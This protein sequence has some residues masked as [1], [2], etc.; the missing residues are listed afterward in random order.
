MAASTV[1]LASSADLAVADVDAGGPFDVRSTTA[2]SRSTE[3]ERNDDIS[4]EP[5]E[6]FPTCHRKGGKARIVS[7][8][9]G[10][11][12]A[13]A[14]T[15]AVLPQEVERSEWNLAVFRKERLFKI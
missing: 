7:G 10:T 11:S 3:K 12:E 5:Y 1:F 13:R 14:G 15:N 9:V 2:T 6:S 8:S 4:M